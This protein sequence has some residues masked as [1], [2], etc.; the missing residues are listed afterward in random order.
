MAAAM[1]RPKRNRNAASEAIS[2][3]PEMNRSRI[4]RGLFRLIAIAGS[5]RDGDTKRAGEVH[6]EKDF[7]RMNLVAGVLDRI[8]F[9][10]HRL[11][12][13][14]AD[15][16]SGRD[17]IDKSILDAFGQRRVDLLECVGQTQAAGAPIESLHPFKICDGALQRSAA[18]AAFDAIELPA[19]GL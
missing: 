1:S 9:V 5:E 3:G 8:A 13:R 16:F 15:G 19:K 12:Q 18:G 2:T 7:Q 4:S 6:F 11:F 10:Q 14:L 17:R